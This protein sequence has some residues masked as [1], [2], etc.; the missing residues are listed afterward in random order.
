[1]PSAVRRP[2]E[3]LV[4]AL[5][6]DDPPPVGGVDLYWVPLGAGDRF[7]VVRWSGRAFEALAARRGHRGR[8]DL[9]H[10]ALEIRI[11]GH[12]YVVEMT[13]AWGAG[14]LGRGT[15]ATGPVGLR[16]LGRSTLFRYEVHR[17]R[18]GSIPDIAQAIGGAQL[19]TDDID[20]TRALFELVPAFPTATWGRDEGTTG[21]MW[22]SNS[23]VAWLLAK[24]GVD[25]R[26][27]RPPPR[28]RAPGWSAGLEI[29]AR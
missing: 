5:P 19:M 13:P 10:A 22:N 29:A 17:W 12:R 16:A 4:R 27:V 25:L 1:M 20:A 21:D 6:T 23:L 3:R 15:V 18:D 2:G 9:Y 28:G 24:A 11:D 26:D 8:C 14:D 7:P